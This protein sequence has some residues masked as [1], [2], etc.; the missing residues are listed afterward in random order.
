MQ[1]DNRLYKLMDWPSIEEIVYSES[2]HPKRILGGHRVKEGS[3]FRCSGPDAVQISVSVSERKK[4][5]QMEKVDDAG[6]LLHLFRL[7]RVLSM[8]SI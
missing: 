5:V 2:S 1:M 7:K 6:F 4:N 8:F 3:L